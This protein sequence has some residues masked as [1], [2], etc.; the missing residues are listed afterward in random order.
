VY[1]IDDEIIP[2]LN[3]LAFIEPNTVT[4]PLK[5]AFEPVIF[6][7]DKSRLFVIEVSPVPLNI[8]IDPVLSLRIPTSSVPAFAFVA[9]ENI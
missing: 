9:Y 6:L 1:N 3:C 5:L 4:S 8:S 7:N 2:I